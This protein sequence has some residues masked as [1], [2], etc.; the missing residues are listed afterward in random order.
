MPIRK[1]TKVLDEQGIKY[2][3]IRHSMAY[4]AQEV[5][6]SAHVPG[7]GMAKTVMVKLDDQMAMVVV[8]ATDRVDLEQLR[9]ATGASKAELASEQEFASL[10][11]DVETGAMPPFGNLFGLPVY[12]D[13]AL[14]TSEEIAFNAGNHT[15]V[16]RLA[17]ADFARIAEPVVG[18]YAR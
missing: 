6:A 9:A 18:R 13:E 8:R 15:E 7:R 12:V 5:A 10:F 3:T 4:T 14:S 16:M 11:P 1:L 17:Y 2:V